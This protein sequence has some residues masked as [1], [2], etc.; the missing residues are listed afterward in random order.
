MVAVLLLQVAGPRR[1]AELVTALHVLVRQVVLLAPVRD[2]R[3]G[4]GGL[5]VVVV[6][7]EPG[8]H[9][10]AVGPAGDGNTLVVHEP[11]LLDRLHAG[12]HVLARPLSPV[13]DARAPA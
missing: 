6:A 7:D 4:D 5:P 11:A 1:A 10:A 3:P 12:H 9:V 2:R 13:L 8:R